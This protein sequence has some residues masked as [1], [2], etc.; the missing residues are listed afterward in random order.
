MAGQVALDSEKRFCTTTL[1]CGLTLVMSPRRE[2]RWQADSSSSSNSSSNTSNSSTANET[3]DEAETRSANK[4]RQ[5]FS[6]GK[7]WE[8]VVVVVGPPSFRGD[9]T[10]MQSVN[11]RAEKAADRAN[12]NTG[13]PS[14]SLSPFF[15]LVFLS[16]PLVGTRSY[17]TPT[18][19][20]RKK[21]STN[22]VTPS[23]KRVLALQRKRKM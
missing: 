22:I 19:A 8:M 13:F 17:E 5:L 6:A 23:K 4:S 15:Y 2:S 10:R 3:G 1:R 18:A 14:A 9:A 16:L 11:S 20:K 7:M 12:L 21:E